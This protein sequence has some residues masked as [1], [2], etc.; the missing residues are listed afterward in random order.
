MRGLPVVLIGAISGVSSA[1]GILGT[2]SYAWLAARIGTVR[3]V[4]ASH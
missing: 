1:L 4:C 2:L 3:S